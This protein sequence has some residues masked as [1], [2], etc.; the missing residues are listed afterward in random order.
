MNGP[1]MNGPEVIG[2]ETTAR[3]MIDSIPGKRLQVI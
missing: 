2:P 1:E 3:P